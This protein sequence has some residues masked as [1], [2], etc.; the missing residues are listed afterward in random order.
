VVAAL[1]LLGAS[2]TSYG[3][4]ESGDLEDRVTIVAHRGSSKAAPENTLAA[5]ERAIEDG[6]HY[7]EIDVQETADGVVVVLHDTDLKRLT[8]LDKKIWEATYDE[9]REL[10]VGSWFSPEF[11]GERIPTLLETFEF[12]DRRIPLII[13]LKLN[14]HEQNLV[15]SLYLSHGVDLA[16][17]DT[18]NRIVRRME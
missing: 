13:E 3:L 12:A 9:I 4:L 1:S 11:A 2:V 8:G 18:T 15:E 14:G 10:D 5:I 17:C 6:A 7:A 16:N